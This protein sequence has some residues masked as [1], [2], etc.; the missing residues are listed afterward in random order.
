[1]KLLLDLLLLKTRM[2]QGQREGVRILQIYLKIPVLFEFSL[3]AAPSLAPGMDSGGTGSCVMPQDPQSQ[4]F[5]SGI[6]DLIVHSCTKKIESLGNSVRVGRGVR[7]RG[8]G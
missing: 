5:F 3:T 4:I 6:S 8:A 7:M 2:I 1:M